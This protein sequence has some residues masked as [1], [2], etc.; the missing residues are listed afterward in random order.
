MA[1]YEVWIRKLYKCMIF[2]KAGHGSG[3]EG[4]RGRGAAVCKHVQ[5]RDGN[6]NAHNDE[7]M[8]PSDV[9]A[10]LPPVGDHRPLGLHIWSSDSLSSAH[11]TSRDQEP[12]QKLRKKNLQVLSFWSTGG[13]REETDCASPHHHPL[14]RAA[15]SPSQWLWPSAPDSRTNISFLRSSESECWVFYCIAFLC[16]CY[17]IRTLEV[18]ECTMK[19]CVL[20]L[21]APLE[22][23]R[24]LLIITLPWALEDLSLKALPAA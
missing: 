15:D 9:N 7:P 22:L 24:T 5:E 13:T 17:I 14:P 6:V 23:Q 4:R 2:E 20:H 1:I 11:L 16:V 3:K 8:E 10:L 12:K 19:W 21:T 18:S